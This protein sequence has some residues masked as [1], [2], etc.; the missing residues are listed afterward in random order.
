MLFKKICLA[1]ISIQIP[2]AV[3][4][5]AKKAL[6]VIGTLIGMK[7]TDVANNINNPVNAVKADNINSVFEE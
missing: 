7:T 5:N 2:K 4:V 6:G 3:I 1:Y